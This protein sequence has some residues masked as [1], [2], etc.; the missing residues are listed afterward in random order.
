MTTQSR[1]ILAALVLAAI[2]MASGPRSLAQTGAAPSQ[3]TPL[4]TAGQALGRLLELIRTTPSVAGITPER[5]EAVMGAKILQA[6]DG[7]A[8]YGFS[9]RVTPSWS[10]GLGI[11]KASN[12]QPTFH[13]N[14]SPNP[15]D[16]SPAMTEICQLDVAAFSSRLESMGFSKTP[17]RAEHGRLLMYVFDRVRAGALEMRIEVYPRG[18]ANEPNKAGHE[19]I[20]M[21]RMS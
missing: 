1:P 3:P 12:A 18:E 6:A 10:Y 11:D 13:F 4:M 19:C 7:S 17:H 16:A 15:P 9:E 5:L 20:E 14:F 8:R 2:A 21:I